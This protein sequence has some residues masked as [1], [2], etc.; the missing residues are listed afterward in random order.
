MSRHFTVSCRARSATVVILSV[1][2]LVCAGTESRAQ[3]TQLQL[4][5]PTE[6]LGASTASAPSREFRAAG[7]LYRVKR[8]DTGTERFALM[9]DDGTI[10]A[11]LAPSSRQ[12]LQRFVGRR[13]GI[14]ARTFGNNDDVAP[15]VMVDR[16]SLTRPPVA[17]GGVQRAQHQQE[18]QPIMMSQGF[19]PTMQVPTNAIPEGAMTTMPDGSF[20]TMP[21]G[22]FATMPEGAITTMPPGT[23]TTMPDGSFFAPGAG[24][25]SCA[26]CANGGIAYDNGYPAGPG[27]ESC[28]S[29]ACT[30]STSCTTC[31]IG[32][33]CCCPPTCGPPGWLWLRGE[34]LLWFSQGMDTPPLVTTSPAGTPPGEA[35]VLGQAGTQILYGNEEVLTDGRSGFRIRFGGFLGPEKRF[36]W[37][38]EYF[39]AG[40]IVELFSASGD[41]N[42]NP[43]IARPFSNVTLGFEDSELVSYPGIL[44][45]E[46]RVASASQFEGAAFRFR[47]T[48]CC[49]RGCNPCDPCGA[50]LG[51]GYPPHFK[52]D[53]TLGYRYYGLRE[54]LA[55]SE[56]L[57]STQIDNPGHIDVLDR[58][59]TRNDFHGAEL[60]TSYEFGRNRWTLEGLMRVAIGGTR[61]KARISGETTI[62]P[63][64][65]PA[66]TFE[67]GLLAQRSNIGEYDRDQFSMIPE[68]G[69]NLGFYLSPR[70]RLT[71]GYT[72]IYWSNVV[73]PGDQIDLDINENLIPPEL[74][75]FDGLLRPE[76]VFRES[77]FW[78]QGLNVG[79][80]YRW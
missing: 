57:S 34:Y 79:L 9:D 38:G 30:T 72:L 74:E 44:T 55:I 21:N 4:G 60:G 52:I 13:I 56:D 6:E 61:Q 53:F 19:D 33:P 36:G 75:P 28:L 47:K 16:V 51:Y 1:A 12:D 29:D 20:T 80:D 22:S 76:F 35:G 58:F 39:D 8:N 78:A 46:V 27:C 50:C 73:R 3:E 68:L 71:F 70:M 69:A 25:E 49:K 32:M 2:V 64:I 54:G 31:G 63:L 26:S 42:G 45:G 14:Q 62:S 77:D 43:I 40:D 41:G 66:E 24:V 7:M 37:E 59:E 67:G 18:L 48:K 15:Y 10:L 65:A 23:V 17:D 5:S 11:F